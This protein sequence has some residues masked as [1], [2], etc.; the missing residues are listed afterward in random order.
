[1]H[2]K[3]TIIHN[4]KVSSK[5]LDFVNNELLEDTE[6][7]QENFWTGFDKVVHELAP[8]NKKLLGCS[9]MSCYLA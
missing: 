8:K 4:L 7:S 2:E 1:M 3:Y 9:S 6:I 5:L